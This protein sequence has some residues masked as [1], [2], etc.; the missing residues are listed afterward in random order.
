[1]NN[2]L[3]PEE[4]V[5]NFDDDQNIALS[6][7]DDKNILLGFEDSSL[8]GDYPPL[9]NKP[10]INGNT[11][12]GDMT[13]ADLGIIEDKNYVHEQTISSNE[14]VIIHNLNKY[15]AVT[16]IDSAGDEVVGEVK[17]DSTN[18]ITIT[19]VSAFKGKATLN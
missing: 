11:L 14:W 16:I 19:F 17:Y 1:M 8:G 15:P 12:L 18:Q 10:K 13:P 3:I 9:R 7:D 6:F 5:M 2:A 4:I